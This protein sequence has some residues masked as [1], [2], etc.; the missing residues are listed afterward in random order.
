MQTNEMGCPSSWLVA[1]AVCDC[2]NAFPSA[3]GFLCNEPEL[4][5]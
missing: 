2:S 3:I 5:V 1:L 4:W